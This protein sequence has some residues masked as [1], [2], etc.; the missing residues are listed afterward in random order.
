M[1]QYVVV[2]LGYRKG[3]DCGKLKNLYKNW[4]VADI[5]VFVL[6]VYQGTDC[7][8]DQLG[9]D[10]L[11]AI[12]SQGVP[13]CMGIVQ[14]LGKLSTKKQ[15]EAM[16]FS[17]R[18]FE[19]EFGAQVKIADNDNS[20]QIK[21]YLTMLQPKPCPWRESRAY[22]LTSSVEFVNNGSDD[23]ELR[24]SGYIRGKPLSV[25]H[26]VHIPDVGSFQLDRIL[27]S[28]DGE[29]DDIVL[30]IPSMSLQQDLR[31]E[32]EVDPFCAEQTW[33]TEEELKEAELHTSVE[34]KKLPKG[35][36]E[37]QAAWMPCDEGGNLLDENLSDADS[38][39]DVT[40]GD[41]ET[42]DMFIQDDEDEIM[43]QKMV[44]EYQKRRK[45]EAEHRDYPDE[46]DVPTTMEARTRFARYR[47]LKSFR[48]S[49]WDPKESLP[50]EY[51]RL[52]EFEDFLCTQKDVLSRN[53][54]VKKIMDSGNQDDE[55]AQGYVALG[56][57]VTLCLRNVPK[58][59]MAM[60]DLST[61]LIV[62]SVLPH[63][64]R[65]SVINFNIQRNSRCSDDT[66]KSKDRLIFQC[67]FRRFEG[68]PIFSDQ[69]LKSDKHK[70][71][72]YMPQQGWCAASVYGPTMFLP[73]PVLVFRESGNGLEVV[74]TGNL[75][76]VNPDRVVLKRI[77][78][79]GV[80]VKV[81]RRKAVIRYMF[82]KPEDVRWFKPIELTSKHGL[83]GH[84][85]ESLGTHGDFKAI[86]NKPIQQHDTVCMYLYK[87]VYPK[88]SENNQ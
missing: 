15:A 66:I 27:K 37:Y 40:D 44:D 14:G 28:M 74:A 48:T 16:K 33:P 57:H 68:F 50:S 43:R 53:N 23:G 64:N 76:S 36:S 11:T 32:A 19:T 52:H 75:Q 70:F 12:R 77:V 25:N 21:R 29:M 34:S 9:E 86:F 67:G 31:Y 3:K 56:T 4:Q 10:I 80:P 46:V 35:M 55:A 49:P 65:L 8:V 78:L 47:G 30:A 63:E 87:R 38:T 84:V 20:A 26:L 24:V 61:P 83:T 60:R 2:R 5:I 51:A 54:E 81:K 39:M 45:D 41:G 42:D 1:R 59:A 88:M 22:M 18:F 6:P 73:A 82:H 71:Q 79:T 62:S 72:R 58:K 85:K 17:R 13:A 69:N 7:C